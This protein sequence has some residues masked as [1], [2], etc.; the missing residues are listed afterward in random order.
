MDDLFGR[1]VQE[2]WEGERRQALVVRRDDGWAHR[3][4]PAMWFAPLWRAEAAITGHVRGRVL[5]VGCGAGRH[6]LHFRARTLE[7]TGLDRSE[8]ALAVCRARGCT[9]LPA[10]SVFETA[11][12]AG[13]FDTAVLF[14][15]NIGMGGTPDGVRRMLRLLAEAVAPDGTVVLASQDV[16]LTRN[17]RHLDYHAANRKAGRPI[18]QIRM[19]LEY[20]GATGGWF[21]WLHPLPEELETLAQESGWQVALLESLEGGGYGA[22]LSRAR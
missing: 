3:A 16:S 6:L 1:A 4:S 5:D 18:G 12:P 9:V 15:N 19:R 8:G 22:V 20:A 14:G 17:R 21:D 13:G 11:L 7:A 2:Y 10:A